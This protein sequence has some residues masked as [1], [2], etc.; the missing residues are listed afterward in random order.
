ML[1]GIDL[2]ILAHAAQDHGALQIE[3]AAI[4]LE[5]LFDLHRELAGGR[6]DQRLGLART[7][8]HMADGKLLQQ[9]QAESGGLAGAGLGDAQKVAARQQR[10]NGAGLDRGGSGVIL[11][12][13]RAEDRLGNAKRGKS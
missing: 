10:R 6:Q 3:K 8:R 9:R 5:A 12:R 4:G 11:C 7:G 1:H 13:K 2:G